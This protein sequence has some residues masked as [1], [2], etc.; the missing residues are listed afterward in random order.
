MA[1][2]GGGAVEGGTRE[3]AAR[4]RERDEVSGER[5]GQGR[6]EV[7]GWGKITN[8][9]P[10]RGAPLECFFHSNGAP[11]GPCAISILFFR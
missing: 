4:W 5:E 7:Y 10:P 9:A 3:G 1:A 8:G 6:D 2:L 11:A